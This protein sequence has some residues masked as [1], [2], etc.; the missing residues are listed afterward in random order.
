MKTGAILSALLHG[1]VLLVLLLGIPDLFRSKLEPPPV[2]P[3]EIVNIA[4]I[5]QAPDL[6]AKPKN[7]GPKEE[8]KEKPEPPKPQPPEEVKPEPEPEKKLEP[9][10]EPT[11]EPAPEPEK[12][13]E[14]E[15]TM[16]DLLAPIEEEKPKEKPKKK[17]KPKKK[18]KK[19]KPKKD[20]TSLLKNIEDSNSSADGKSQPEQDESSTSDYAANNIGDI[21]SITELDLIR[22]QFKDIWNVPA[23][24]RETDITISIKIEL[25]PDATIR[26]AIIVNT[27]KPKSDPYVQQIAD[28]AMRAVKNPK[29]GPLKIPLQRYEELKVIILDFNPKDML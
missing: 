6:K 2:I 12:P 22:R 29:L 11:P 28:S 24:A 15:L 3:I 7:D 9:E 18:K 8:P 26:E 14:P 27:S 1:F 13:A 25:N 23:G 20:F 5:T 21:L 4:D 10:P 17:D 19:S 16:D